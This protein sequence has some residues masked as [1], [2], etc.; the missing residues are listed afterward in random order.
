MNALSDLFFNK[1]ADNSEALVQPSLVPFYKANDRG[2]TLHDPPQH[3]D[4][5]RLIVSLVTKVSCSVTVVGCP[6]RKPARI[7]QAIVICLSRRMDEWRVQR[8]EWR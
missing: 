5:S 3:P 7:H 8:Q 2:A 6:V 4:R 1:V